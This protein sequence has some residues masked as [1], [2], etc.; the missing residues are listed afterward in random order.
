MATQTILVLG[1]YGFFGERIS[2]A[3]A[4]LPG[5]RVLLAGRDPGRAQATATSLHLPP[6]HGLALDAHDGRLSA[7]LQELD[8]DLVI[9]TAGP[10]QG[11]NYAVARA[12]IEAGCHYIDV[13]D[14]RQF[15][16]GIRALDTAARDRGLTVVS[17]ASSV[18]ALSSAV[19]ER[20]RPRFARLESIR[21]GISTGGKLPGLAS[22]RSVFGYCGKPFECWENGHW[23][24]GHG[25]LDLHRRPF[26]SPVGARWLGRC[27]V[28]DLDLFPQRYAPVRTVTFHAGFASSIGHLAVWG[29]AQLVRSHLLKDARPFARPLQRIGGLCERFLSRNG[30]MFVVLEGIRPDGEPARV[31]WTLVAR[32]NHGPHVP[33]G[34]A[35]ALAR[36]VLGTG[37]PTGA[38]P[39]M[40][41]LSV[42]EYLEPLRGLDIEEVVE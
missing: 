33:C 24:T 23:T 28:P 22:V 5:A 3:L 31:T 2:A 21:L 14:G 17:G 10:F 18:P 32:R 39:C 30:A 37:L 13:A 26:P 29:L 25:W 38:M 41:L 15:V 40:G 16:A 35:I 9:H 42:E 4:S 1:G 12:A 36:K 8:V 7:R 20:Y 6:S 19:V 11:Q 34:A 27:D